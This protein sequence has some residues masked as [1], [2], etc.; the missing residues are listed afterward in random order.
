MADDFDRERM[1]KIKSEILGV[2]TELKTITNTDNLPSAPTIMSYIRDQ[3]TPLLKSKKARDLKALIRAFVSR[4]TV[5]NDK[6]S[7]CY[8]CIALSMTV[9][10]PAKPT[11]A[12]VMTAPADNR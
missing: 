1:K 10:P 12:V 2:R 6:V 7:V 9:V 5:T 8:A 3:F 11:L 4:I